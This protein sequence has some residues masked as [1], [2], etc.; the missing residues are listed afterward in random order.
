M[1]VVE[2]SDALHKIDRQVYRLLVNREM[3]VAGHRTP[4]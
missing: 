2:V 1:V 4:K 3:L